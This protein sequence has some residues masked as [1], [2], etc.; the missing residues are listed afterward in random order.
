M[1]I[2][3]RTNV[4]R[5]PDGQERHELYHGDRHLGTIVR[6][7]AEPPRWRY[8]TATGESSG[9]P[10]AESATLALLDHERAGAA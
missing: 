2:E 4:V 7:D 5:T 6:S 10:D 1:A 8:R 3:V 9:Y